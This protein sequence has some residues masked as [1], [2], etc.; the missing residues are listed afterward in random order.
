MAKRPDGLSSRDVM[1]RLKRYKSAKNNPA[2]RESLIN[3]VKVREGEGA[4][5]EIN[6]EFT[7]FLKGDVGGCHTDFTNQS[8]MVVTSSVA[9]C[10]H[11]AYVNNRGSFG[12]PDCIPN[13]PYKTKFK[14]NK[15]E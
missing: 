15:G 9:I 13:N 7:S 2:M 1:G 10:N 12:C 3:Q 5:K 6:K 14:P 4:A 11:C 8:K